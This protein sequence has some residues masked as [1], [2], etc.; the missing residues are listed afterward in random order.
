MIS[1]KNRPKLILGTVAIFLLTLATII[2]LEHNPIMG[3]I[4]SSKLPTIGR[5]DAP[6]QMIIFEDPSCSECREFHLHVLPLIQEHYVERG[7]V[8]CSLVMLDFLDD[9]PP[10]AVSSLAVFEKRPDL[11]FPFVDEIFR[12]GKEAK[13]PGIDLEELTGTNADGHI[14]KILDE[15]DRLG[16]K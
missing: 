15:H 12:H 10:L 4:D 1:Y 3:R 5:P 14:S 6:I 2:V 11:F 13:L 8:Q 16:K 7:T 9:S